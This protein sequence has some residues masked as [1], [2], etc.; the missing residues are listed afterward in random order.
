M[1]EDSIHIT[2]NYDPTPSGERR[3]RRI[4]QRRQRRRS[5]TSQFVPISI[6]QENENPQS[7][8]CAPTHVLSG[9][10]L[11]YSQRPNVIQLSYH[12]STASES[13]SIWDGQVYQDSETPTIS[14]HNEATPSPGGGSLRD[15]LS[16]LPL[17]E[18]IDE[19][20][21]LEKINK[22]RNSS[23]SSS[24]LSGPI[25]IL[26]SSPKSDSEQSLPD[27]FSHSL[28]PSPQLSLPFDPS[29]LMD[30][31]GDIQPSQPRNWQC[32]NRV[33]DDCSDDT[34]VKEILFGQTE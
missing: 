23:S 18:S 34:F 25:I 22:R 19:G 7:S 1:S 6:S 14:S 31:H 3:D 32:R 27:L 8:A 4:R 11:S 10:S 30:I 29:P 15:M 21:D 33:S 16:P 17:F 12:A 9:T 28:S 2:W 26:S 5:S 24:V 13:S 20:D